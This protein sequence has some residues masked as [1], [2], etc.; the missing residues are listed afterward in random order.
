MKTT[1]KKSAKKHF[2]GAWLDDSTFK[3]IRSVA[4]ANDRS[5]AYTIVK[6]LS[7]GVT[8]LKHN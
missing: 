1:S 3:Q 6:L 7:Q 4:K 8:H 5:L 2:V